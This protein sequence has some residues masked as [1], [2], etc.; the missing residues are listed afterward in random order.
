MQR[1]FG[2]GN[3]SD[4]SRFRC[5]WLVSYAVW[6]CVCV[7]CSIDALIGSGYAWVVD[8]RPEW[9]CRSR[10]MRSSPSRLNALSVFISSRFIQLGRH[11]RPCVVV[12]L[13][14]LTRKP[15]YETTTSGPRRVHTQRKLAVPP[16]LFLRQTNPH[17]GFSVDVGNS[18]EKK[19]P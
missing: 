18:Q 10:S 12:P 6:M 5:G 1:P 7:R 13:P 8:R 9:A 16:S 19:S 2:C 11:L 4:D 14:A 15:F 3:D 17:G